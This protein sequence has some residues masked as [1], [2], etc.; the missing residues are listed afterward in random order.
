[1]DWCSTCVQRPGPEEH[2]S[3]RDWNSHDQRSELRRIQLHADSH[4]LGRHL[5]RHGI[6]DIGHNSGMLAECIHYPGECNTSK[7]DSECCGGYTVG[8]RVHL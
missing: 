1:M 2:A 8:G 5:V 3:L 6:M 4:S 7:G